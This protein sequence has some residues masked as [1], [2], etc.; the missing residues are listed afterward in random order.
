[1]NEQ[2]DARP[3]AFLASWD[4]IKRANQTLEESNIVSATVAGLLLRMADTYARLAS[5]PESVGQEAAQ[6]IIEQEVADANT[7]A[8]AEFFRKDEAK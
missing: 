7:E 3:A 5:V 8:A 6:R 1:M 2:P 4:L